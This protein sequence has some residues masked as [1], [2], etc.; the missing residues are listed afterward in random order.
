MDKILYS[1]KK[2]LVEALEKKFGD[3]ERPMIGKEIVELLIEGDKS[4]FTLYVSYVQ[5]LL[6]SSQFTEEYIA[7]RIPTEQQ[8]VLQGE[9]SSEETPILWFHLH[10]L[11]EEVLRVVKSRNES[12]PKDFFFP[13]NKRLSADYVDI[14][15]ILDD[16][17]SNNKR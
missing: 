17:P 4:I 7:E 10:A 14:N 13:K 6:Q 3:I 16:Q 11:L 5:M 15:N 2:E 8:R 12:T 1:M 9:F